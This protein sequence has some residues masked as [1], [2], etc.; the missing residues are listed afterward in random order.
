MC[1]K[2]ENRTKEELAE[3]ILKDTKELIEIAKESKLK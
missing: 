2:P 3:Q 1:L